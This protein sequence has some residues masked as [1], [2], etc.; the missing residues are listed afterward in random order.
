MINL[1]QSFKLEQR[2]EEP[3][4]FVGRGSSPFIEGLPIERYEEIAPVKLGLV[5]TSN[6]RYTDLPRDCYLFGDLQRVWQESILDALTTERWELPP[7]SPPV[8]N[9]EHC[10][11]DG[12][13]RSAAASQHSLKMNA[14][15]VENQ[16]DLDN[17]YRLVSAGVLSWPHGELNHKQLSEKLKSAGSDLSYW[18]YRDFLEDLRMSEG[19]EEEPE[20]NSCLS[21]PQREKLLNYFVSRTI[22]ERGAYFTGKSSLFCGTS[23]GIC[24]LRYYLRGMDCDAEIISFDVDKTYQHI[25]QIARRN[26]FVGDNTLFSVDDVA[27]E[28]MCLLANYL[29][30]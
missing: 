5:E 3:G 27:Q 14:L 7:I 6:F 24:D 22:H 1:S 20:E 11:Y 19:D 15:L 12:N 30:K 26:P 16:G 21:E 4:D 13:H 23:E 29:E 17:I 10:I 8:I 28:V 25:R 9:G 2:L 18:E